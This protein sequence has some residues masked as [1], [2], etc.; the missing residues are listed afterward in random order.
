M[1]IYVVYW[2]H[3]LIYGGHL[4]PS[5]AILIIGHANRTKLQNGPIM[6]K[7]H[8]QVECNSSLG[9]PAHSWDLNFHI[10]SSN[11]YCRGG[12]SSLLDVWVCYMELECHLWNM[13]D[14]VWGDSQTPQ[15]A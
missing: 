15:D 10:W 12:P 1:T 13:F 8:V 6:F 9:I 3:S 5:S 2:Q 7:I 11:A 4:Q 14:M